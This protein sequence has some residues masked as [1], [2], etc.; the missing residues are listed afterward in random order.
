[1][2]VE[3]QYLAWVT[4]LTLLMRIPWL[5]DK[6]RVR[7]LARVTGYP[8]DSEPLSDMGHRTWVAHEDAVQNL[9]VFAVLIGILHAIGES[10]VWTRLAAATYF[11]ARL[12]HFLVYAFGIPRLKT[13]AFLVAFA[14]QLVLAWH[15]LAQP[16]T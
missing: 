13:V 11:W 15:L 9:I 3:L 6:I 16:W 5:I 14:A 10:S 4:V 7:G 1:M 2:T 12:G 8:R